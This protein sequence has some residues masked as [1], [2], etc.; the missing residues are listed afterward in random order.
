MDCDALFMDDFFGKGFH[1]IRVEVFS[2]GPPID[3]KDS[4]RIFDE[5]FRL[6]NNE[7]VKGTGH[8]LH[9][10]KNVIEVHGGI[11]GHTPKKFGNLFYFIIP[12]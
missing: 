12:A 2:S 6:A 8:G 7:S 1:G 9:F 11:V 3:K 4:E 10:V 5:G